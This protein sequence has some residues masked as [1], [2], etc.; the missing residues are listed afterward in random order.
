MYIPDQNPNIIGILG[1]STKLKIYITVFYN[2]Q[3]TQTTQ[4][5]FTTPHI[6]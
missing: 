2:V 1:I 6:N 5:N 4:Q 3:N